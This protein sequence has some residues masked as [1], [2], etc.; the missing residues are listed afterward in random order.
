[1]K[2]LVYMSY[3]CKFYVQVFQ[4]IL[5]INLEICVANM[6]RNELA[7]W[8]E[9][10]FDQ[11]DFVESDQQFRSKPRGGRKRNFPTVEMLIRKRVTPPAKLDEYHSWLHEMETENQ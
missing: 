2:S 10:L 1:M 11:G 4:H 9:L 3:S 7:F 6:S 5:L 8:I